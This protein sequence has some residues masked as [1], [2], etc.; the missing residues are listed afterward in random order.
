M[1]LSA[2]GDAA[3]CLHQ[4]RFSPFLAGAGW[5]FCAWLLLWSIRASNVA[6]HAWELHFHTVTPWF[7]RLAGVTRRLSFRF[8][9]THTPTRPLVGPSI[10]RKRAGA[11][12]EAAPD[13]HPAASRVGG[14]A[15][16]GGVLGGGGD[17][18]DDDGRYDE[19][20]YGGRSLPR[21]H[22]QREHRRRRRRW[23]KIRPDSNSRGA[24]A[25]HRRSVRAPVGAYLTSVRPSSNR[26]L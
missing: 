16:G 3:N 5:W 20:A 8:T 22:R 15:D 6:L 9:H 2:R 18:S 21:C 14:D 19:R 25:I 17:G 11:V 12:G 23:N 1:G 4:A 10:D 7:Y 26:P 24:L 13:E